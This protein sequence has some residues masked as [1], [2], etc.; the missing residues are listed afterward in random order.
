MS[1]NQVEGS[2]AAD[3][4]VNQFPTIFN[5]SIHTM[6]GEKFSISLQEDAIPFCVKTPRL[7]PFAYRDKL[8]TELDLL[9][10]EGIIAPVTQA[11]EW[12]APIVV[13]PKKGSYKIRICVDLSYLNKYVWREHYQSPIPAEAVVDITADEA[14][15]FTIIDAAKGYHQCPLDEA[16][17]LYT[18]FITLFGHF[19]YLRAPYGLS[20]IAEHYNRRMA[21]AFDGLTGFRCVVDD[22]IIYDKDIESHVEHVKQFLQRCQEWLISINKDKLAF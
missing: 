6:D 1:V 14:K 12:C 13:V 3:D 5:G 9:Q 20:S 18:T 21:E 7:I 4:L 17:Q 2:P 11:T 15:Y 22:V 10:E 16:S 19:R 8:K